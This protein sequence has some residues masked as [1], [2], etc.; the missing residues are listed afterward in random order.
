MVMKIGTRKGETLSGNDDV[1][2]ID[3]LYGMGGNDQLF[4]YRGEDWLYGGSGDDRLNGGEG[5]DTDYLFGE[6]GND[7]LFGGVGDDYLDGGA[8][9]DE[10]W[11]GPGRD[12]L[13]GGSGADTFKWARGHADANLLH[14]DPYADT[15]TDFE[16]GIDKID[17]SHFDADETTPFTRTRKGEPGNDAFTYIGAEAEGATPGPGQLTLTYDPLSNYTTLRAYTNTEAG[18]DFTLVI[19]GQVNPATDIMF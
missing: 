3:Y 12:T 15:I 5:A 14:L 2:E 10:L 11:G 8:G 16:T 6:E 7:T 9:N 1:N 13:T 4:G 18:A 19:F 17:I